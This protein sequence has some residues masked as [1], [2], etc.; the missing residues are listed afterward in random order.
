MAQSI[1]LILVLPDT[2]VIPVEGR[3][4]SRSTLARHVASV[5]ALFIVTVALFT[6]ASTVAAWLSPLFVSEAPRVAGGGDPGNLPGSAIC[7]D[8]S[9]ADAAKLQRGLARMREAGEGE[10]LYQVLIDHDVCI[11]VR[12]L[13]RYAGLA[14]PRQG[15][16]AGWTHSTVEIARDHLATA[17]SDVLATTLVHEATHIERSVKGATCLDHN[18][19]TFLTNRV[20]LDEEIAAHAAEAA[21]WVAVYGPEGKTNPDSLSAWENRLA[22]AYLAGPDVFADF[23]ASFRAETISP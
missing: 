22:A 13:T 18:A 17:G 21:W 4:R 6:P 23:I 14:L 15:D 8:V 19:C 1:P 12:D 10:R 9:Q 11:T 5:A 7:R 16:D 20:V 2:P 3:G